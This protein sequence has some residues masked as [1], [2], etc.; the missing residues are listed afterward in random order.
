MK[1]LI[2]CLIVVAI[3]SMLLIR[4]AKTIVSYFKNRV[5]EMRYV[6][7][8][9]NEDANAILSKYVKKGKIASWAYDIVISE[10][11][12]YSK[13]AQFLNWEEYIDKQK[14]EVVKLPKYF[15]VEETADRKVLDEECLSRFRDFDMNTYMRTKILTDYDKETYDYLVGMWY[16]SYLLCNTLEEAEDSVKKVFENYVHSIIVE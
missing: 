3:C 6:I 5:Q 7:R 4:I 1:S 10:L 15:A 9:E 12:Q 11:K 8:T 16:F 14:L 13:R 2:V